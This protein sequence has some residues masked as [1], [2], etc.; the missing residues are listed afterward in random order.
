VA[1]PHS[2]VPPSPK[3]PQAVERVVD[4]LMLVSAMLWA[5]HQIESG[6]PSAAL[7]TLKGEINRHGNRT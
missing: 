6:N 7:E 4:E 3:F 5:V 1:V 2:T